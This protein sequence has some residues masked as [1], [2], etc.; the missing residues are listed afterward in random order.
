M[1]GL[2]A[3]VS[4][5]YVCAL[6]SQKSEEGVRCPAPGATGTDDC[7]TLWIQGLKPRPSGE[8]DSALNNYLSEPSPTTSTSSETASRVSAGM[9]SVVE[10]CLTFF[11]F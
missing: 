2:P 5:N 4:M 3:Y 8:V 7:K 11:M 1:D 10:L 9:L 6:Y